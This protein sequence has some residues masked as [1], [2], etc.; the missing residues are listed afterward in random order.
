MSSFYMPIS[1]PD[2]NPSRHRCFVSILRNIF[3]LF[4]V[5]IL[6][7]VSIVLNK[8]IDRMKLASFLKIKMQN[9]TFQVIYKTVTIFERSYAGYQEQYK[10]SYRVIENMLS[11]PLNVGFSLNCR[12]KKM[13]K[14]WARSYTIFTRK[15]HMH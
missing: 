4:L 6:A 7:T 10:T 1:L 2:S 14:K 12:E 13:S 9:L 3:V 8:C 11:L 5:L 15:N